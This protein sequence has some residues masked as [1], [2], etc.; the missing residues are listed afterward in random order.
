MQM[1]Q[2]CLMHNARMLCST[3]FAL[4]AGTDNSSEGSTYARRYRHLKKSKQGLQIEVAAY[5]RDSIPPPKLSATALLQHTDLLISQ[6]HYQLGDSKWSCDVYMMLCL[7]HRHGCD[8]N[9]SWCMH[10]KV[11]PPHRRVCVL[12]TPCPH[13]TGIGSAP[14]AAGSTRP[15]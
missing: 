4:S 7:P 12:C 3:A 9:W 2:S 15:P 10:M 14:P 11:C 1:Q 13:H 5:A 6:R 8:S